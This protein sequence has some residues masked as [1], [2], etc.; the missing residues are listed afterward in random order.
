MIKELLIVILLL[1]SSQSL[2][3]DSNSSKL[4]FIPNPC[5]ND[6]DQDKK[7]ELDYKAFKESC[8]GA[9]FIGDQKICFLS[10]YK[11]FMQDP[12]IK[13]LGLASRL[14][15][16]F[17]EMDD[18]E[19]INIGMHTMRISMSLNITWVDH[20]LKVIPGSQ[21]IY[22]SA[23]DQK[24]IWSP[25]IAIVTNIMSQ[26]KEEEEFIVKNNTGSALASKIFILNTLV[27]CEMEFQNFPF[28]Q[29]TCNLEVC[30]SF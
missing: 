14:Y 16:N 8:S 18:V 1:H 24:K 19:I 29:H 5:S 30:R 22:L 9:E 28:D 12:P 27:K 21:F 26:K 23:K 2:C 20:R 17:I 6:I 11:G 13:F 25:R 7:G 15:L 4:H 10:K 3:S